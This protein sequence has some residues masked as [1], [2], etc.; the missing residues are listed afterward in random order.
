M[1]KRE[2]LRVRGQLGLRREF[3]DSQGYMEGEKRRPQ[4]CVFIFDLHI[5]SPKTLSH[6]SQKGP[7]LVQ[8]HRPLE[9]SPQSSQ[10][11]GLVPSLQP[12][13][14]SE[15]VITCRWEEED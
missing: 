15:Y 7:V 2:E 6:L 11:F 14:G 1:Q 5:L 8:V 10:L 9:F 12:L 3:K 13:A 4:G